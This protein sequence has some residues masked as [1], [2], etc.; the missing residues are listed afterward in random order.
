[1]RRKAF[2]QYGERRSAQGSSGR[3]ETLFRQAE[4]VLDQ[5]CW[6]AAEVGVSGSMMELPL[7]PE[8]QLPPPRMAS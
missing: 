4:L 1:M 2:L 5:K 3:D 7:G 6:L 8:A